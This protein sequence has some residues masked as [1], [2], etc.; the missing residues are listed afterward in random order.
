[1]PNRSTLSAQAEPSTAPRAKRRQRLSISLNAL[2]RGTPVHP[3]ADD[4]SPE[5]R[6]DYRSLLDALNRVSVGLAWFT[7]DG[8]LVHANVT[9]QRLLQESTPTDHLHQQIVDLTDS[10]CLLVAEWD[11]EPPEAVRPMASR[12]LHTPKFRYVLRGSFVAMNLFGHGGTLLVGLERLPCEP[13]SEEALQE[14]WG[15]T[16]AEARVARQ[17]V[18]GA[19]N[20][21]IAAELSISPHTVRHHVEQVLR[22]LRLSSRAG[23]G[24]RLLAD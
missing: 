19:S 14:R 22:K 12:V 17:L 6:Q 21:R 11:G 9:L 20:T 5:L 18:H 16:A 2:S 23:V 1:M 13:L 10:L 8:A 24:G 15:L 3:F 7:C 4:P